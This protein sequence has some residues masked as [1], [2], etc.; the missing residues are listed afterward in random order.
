[1][2]LRCDR[3]ALVLFACQ[4]ESKELDIL[5]SALRAT[6]ASDETEITKDFVHPPAPD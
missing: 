2:Y 3:A 6:Y 4:R 5:F 1:M